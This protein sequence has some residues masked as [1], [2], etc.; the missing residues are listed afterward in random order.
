MLLFLQNHLQDQGLYPDDGSFRFTSITFEDCE[1]FRTHP[2]NKTR[3]S[4]DDDI[5]ASVSRSF[6]TP[7]QTSL[8][9]PAENF[10]KSIKRDASL[11]VAFKDGKFWDNWRRSTL[12]IAR[13]QDADQVLDL[14]CIPVTT[15]D[16]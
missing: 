15:E 7:N 9:T 1:I 16:I 5:R 2:D 8:C 12:A 6:L 3:A 10:K 4:Q 14:N 11:F 13:A